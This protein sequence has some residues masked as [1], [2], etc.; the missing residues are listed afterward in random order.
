MNKRIIAAFAAALSLV[1]YSTGAFAQT[2]GLQGTWRFG[3]DPDD[4]GTAGQWYCQDLQDSVTLPGSCEE[5]GFGITMTEPDMARLTRKIS[6]EGKAWYQKDIEVPESWN[7]RNVELFL[8]RCHWESHVWVDDR[9]IGTANSLSVPHVY[10]LGNLSAGKHRLTICVDNTYKIPVGTWAHGITR[11]TQT[12]WNGIIGRIELRAVSPLRISNAQVHPDHIRVFTVNETGKAQKARILGSEYDIPEGSDCITVPFKVG[13]PEWDE[14]DRN[15]Q[16]VDIVLENDDYKDT[17]TA[18][19]ANRV[20]RIQDKQVLVNDNPILLRGTVD[21]CVYPLTGYPP[22]DKAEWTRVFDI[23]KAHGFNY[24][25]Y[26]SWCPPKAAFEAADEL[27]FYLQV[28][29]PFWSMDAPHYGEDPSRDQWLKDEVMRI[30]DEYGNHP[31]FGLMAMG[32]ESSGPLYELVNAARDYDKRHIYRAENGNTLAH[33]DFVETGLRGTAGPRTDWDRW[34]T[35]G[36]VADWAGEGNVNTDAGAGVSQNTGAEIPTLGHE[37]GQWEIYPDY[38]EIAKYT[39]NLYPYNYEKYRESLKAHGMMAQNK[40][41]A[42]ASGK[43]STILYKEDVEAGIRTFPYAGFHILEARDYPGQGAAL[44]GWLDAFWDSKGLIAP[45]EFKKF[46]DATVLLMRMP[47]RI[48]YSGDTFK[49]FAQIAHYGKE[50]FTIDPQWKLVDEAGRT[51]SEG[52]LAQSEVAAGRITNLGA[53][54]IPL[55]CKEACKYTVVLSDSGSEENSWDIWVYPETKITEP[56]NVVISYRYDRKTV[57]ALEEG[58]RVI[59]FSDPTKGIFPVE[60][61]FMGGDDVRCFEVSSKHNAVEG[62]FM[63]TFWNMMLF[64]QTG[65][66]GILCQEDH[67]AL[68]QFPTSYHSDWQWADILG[69]Y[70]AAQS[71]RTAGAP[72][73]YCDDMERQWGDARNRSKAIVLN[74]A[75]EGYRPIVQAIDNYKRNYRLGVIFETKVGKG[76]LLV[77]ALDLDTDIEDRPAARC[78][79]QSLLDYVSGDSFK[80]EY[81]LDPVMLKTVLRCK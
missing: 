55:E 49:G 66:M 29:I 3:L 38:D 32:N 70:S 61:A 17:Y 50:N 63:P 44:V 6:Y 73:E 46:S 41:F 36:W 27:G 67:P 1:A 54:E 20:I 69:R 42:K 37:I 60:P 23:C 22:M 59:L 14:F 18:E 35:S 64:N 26:H 10:S 74:D 72:E 11:D 25:R 34:T 77:C 48:F 21:E 81:E 40:D 45:E 80:P 2:I 68:S 57:K 43:L 9:F 58:K 51:V 56:E 24:I 5:Q 13:G 19:Y 65:T 62:S 33:G 53:V 47:E 39:G 79:R 8:E 71:F 76:S 30:L 7:G 12:N 52:R 4:K 78:L 31:S 75:P 28:E 15:M 16:K